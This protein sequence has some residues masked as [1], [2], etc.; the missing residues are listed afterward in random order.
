MYHVLE[1]KV[2][3]TYKLKSRHYVVLTFRRGSA[4][5]DNLICR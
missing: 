4:K 3:L 2:F 1:N 5:D